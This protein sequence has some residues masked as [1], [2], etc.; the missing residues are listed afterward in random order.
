MSTP[1]E[2]SPDLWL[3]A[4]PWPARDAHKHS[5]GALGV[6]TGG[7]S[8]TGAARLAAQAG[9]RVGAGLVT[10]YSP[11]SAVLV[12]ASHATAI[13][14]EAFADTTDLAVLAAD[15]DCVLIGPA[16]GVHER[17]R[18]NTL[19]ILSKAKCAVLDADA[20]TVFSDDAAALFSKLRS[21]DVI[22]PHEGE[23]NRLF[24]GLLQQVGR[25]SAARKAAQDT[26]AVTVLKGPQTLIAAPL[27][28]LCRQSDAPPWLAT[29][30]SGD[31]L[32]GLIGGLC[33]QGMESYLAACAAVWIHAE[34]G[35]KFGPGLIADDLA[36]LI[37]VVLSD[38]HKRR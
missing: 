22:T 13:M 33:A 17:T 25:E 24:S 28:E 23:F 20:L 9:L 4:F 3:D 12:N 5:R 18:N 1:T 30:G 35:R 32:A 7:A 11:P 37:P 36:G 16:A 15:A 38:L 21:Q 31:T 8:S 26:G 14:V 2:N 19:A 10:L 34:A 27:G 29:A 6:V